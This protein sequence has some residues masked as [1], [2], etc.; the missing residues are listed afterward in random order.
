MVV[1]VKK[2]VLVL[3]QPFLQP[4]AVRR[5]EFLEGLDSVHRSAFHL[6]H[7]NQSIRPTI[8]FS[9]QSLVRTVSRARRFIISRLF[10]AH[11]PSEASKPADHT[12]KGIGVPVE[13]T[14][15]VMA[16]ALGHRK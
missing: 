10:P 2:K 13:V 9:T 1:Q 11:R 12:R 16:K 15:V 5:V 7:R 3:D 4:D 8:D 14:V 6:T